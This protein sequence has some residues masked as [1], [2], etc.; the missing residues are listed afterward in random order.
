M[1]KYLAYEAHETIFS[2]SSPASV[3]GDEV[4]SVQLS[5]HMIFPQVCS[6]RKTAEQLC[7]PNTEEESVHMNQRPT[8]REGRLVEVRITVS[9]G[10]SYVGMG[11]D[12][13]YTSVQQSL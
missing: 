1:R 7:P 3:L 9:R 2:L 5:L 11:K 8:A 13:V 6:G 12:K 4:I 10:C